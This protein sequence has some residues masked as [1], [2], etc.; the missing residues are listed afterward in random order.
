M[1]LSCCHLISALDILEIGKAAGTEIPLSPA[2]C[3]SYPLA[4]ASV[5]SPGWCQ[6][7]GVDSPAGQEGTGRDETPGRPQ[8]SAGSR[9]PGLLA[10][11]FGAIAGTMR[12]T[13][14]CPGAFHPQPPP[15]PTGATRRRGAQTW[16]G[17]APATCIPA[18][19]GTAFGQR[20]RRRK[21]LGEFSSSWCMQGPC[22][23]C[24]CVRASPGVSSRRL[25]RGCRF[26]SQTL[27]SPKSP[28]PA[29]P[30]A[31]VDAAGPLGEAGEPGRK[32]SRPRLGPGWG[33]TSSCPPR[34]LGFARLLD[35]NKMHLLAR[36]AG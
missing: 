1:S 22:S 24:V 21:F 30:A 8:L 10:G 3:S 36:Q 12:G 14:H 15:H 6:R 7:E 28:A 2:L 20:R 16:P 13:Q 18:G 31:S 35:W 32:G 4:P 23:H 34:P 33:G 5:N 19:H 27:P 26:L 25:P 11:T 29:C 9:S 17:S